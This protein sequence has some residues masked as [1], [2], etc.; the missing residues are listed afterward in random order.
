M[1]STIL[2]EQISSLKAALATMC[3]MKMNEYLQ[4]SCSEAFWFVFLPALITGW[5]LI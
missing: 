3:F 2:K 4:F 1:K 5:Q